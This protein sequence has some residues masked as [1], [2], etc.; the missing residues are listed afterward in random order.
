LKGTEDTTEPARQP[1]PVFTKQGT[2]YFSKKTPVFLD[3]LNYIVLDE[4]SIE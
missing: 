1:I 3:T 2:I 4:S